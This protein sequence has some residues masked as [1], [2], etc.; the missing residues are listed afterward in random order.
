MRHNHI[1]LTVII[2]DRVQHGIGQ[3]AGMFKARVGYCIK[4]RC[5]SLMKKEVVGS[6]V[7]LSKRCR[8]VRIYG[9]IKAANSVREKAWESAEGPWYTA[10]T[11]SVTV[12]GIGDL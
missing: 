6:V 10:L 12:P 2:L 3:S 7:P 9:L 1:T 5:L 4:I 11:G 8:L